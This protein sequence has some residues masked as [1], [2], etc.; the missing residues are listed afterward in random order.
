M[1]EKSDAMS[2]GKDQNGLDLAN[3]NFGAFQLSANSN[4]GH[5]SLM[6]MASRNVFYDQ[7]F[8]APIPKTQMTQQ[9]GG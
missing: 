6:P 7:N 3:F 2:T 5:H 9:N 4:N 1:D 8:S